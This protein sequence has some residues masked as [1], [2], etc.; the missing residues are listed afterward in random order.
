MQVLS[1]FNFSTGFSSLRTFFLNPS[2]ISSPVIR[3]LC[4]KL[5]WR[6]NGSPS[7]SKQKWKY[8]YGYRRDRPNPPIAP[9]FLE[10]QSTN[11]EFLSEKMSIFLFS[12]FQSAERKSGVPASTSFVPSVENCVWKSGVTWV[13]C[14]SQCASMWITP[15]KKK[16]SFS[17]LT[18]RLFFLLIRSVSRSGCRRRRC[19]LTS[20]RPLPLLHFSFFL[21]GA[22]GGSIIFA[23]SFA[24]YR[25][26]ECAHV[27]TNRD[28][29]LR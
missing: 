28:S 3:C 17:F 9:G 13:T 5:G 20:A 8:S 27:H 25:N 24:T 14:V 21:C 10:S 6:G 26:I 12:N 7:L 23:S 16:I 18:T 15:K 22:A 2:P 29:L 4:Q 1:C 19:C 11:K